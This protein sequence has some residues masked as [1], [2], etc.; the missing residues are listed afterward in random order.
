MATDFGKSKFCVRCELDK[1]IEEFATNTARTDGL[2]VWCKTCS[3]DYHGD[4]HY[5]RKY[6]VTSETVRA[7]YTEQKGICPICEFWFEKLDVDHDHVTGFIRGL[8]CGNCNRALGI[9]SDDPERL[10][11]AITYLDHHYAN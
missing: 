10:Q 7:L 5:Q 9:F 11:R 6:G 1:P 4:Y 3:K 8:L 2:Q